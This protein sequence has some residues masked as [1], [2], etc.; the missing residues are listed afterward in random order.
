[1]KC[2]RRCKSLH[3][4]KHL[5]SCKTCLY[6]GREIGLALFISLIAANDN[7]H[8]GFQGFR[9]IMERCGGKRHAWVR[10]LSHFSA[11]ISH[12]GYREEK[13]HQQGYK[14]VEDRS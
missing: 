7:R 11:E 4:A 10:V 9:P 12:A 8:L 3:G 5:G 2:G 1:M 14:V 13:M 6:T